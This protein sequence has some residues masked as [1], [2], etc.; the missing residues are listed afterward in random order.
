MCILIGPNVPKLIVKVSGTI[1]L[2]GPM[3]EN[4]ESCVWL[5]GLGVGLGK[6]K[7]IEYVLIKII[8]P[9]GSSHNV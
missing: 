6:G 8:K 4:A 7:S 9:M 3:A 5:I 1:T 2:W